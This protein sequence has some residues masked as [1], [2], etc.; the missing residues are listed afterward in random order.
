V[1]AELA[2]WCLSPLELWYLFES[3]MEYGLL[4]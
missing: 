3:P 2:L 1:S 4:M